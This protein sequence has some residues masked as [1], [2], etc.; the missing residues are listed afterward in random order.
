M[1]SAGRG[2]LFADVPLRRRPVSAQCPHGRSDLLSQLAWR[3]LL[4]S[5]GRHSRAWT[6]ITASQPDQCLTNPICAR[7]T[8]HSKCSLPRGGIYGERRVSRGLAPSCLPGGPAPCPGRPRASVH[9]APS[10]AAVERAVKERAGGGPVP[11]D[12]SRH[13]HAQPA[14]GTGSACRASRSRVKSPASIARST[15][16]TSRKSRRSPPRSR[17]VLYQ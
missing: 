15:S 5:L 8:S 14:R 1:S 17:V 3:M 6:M 11:D 16:A 10:C 12:A 2:Q 9:P 4:L 13:P 7:T